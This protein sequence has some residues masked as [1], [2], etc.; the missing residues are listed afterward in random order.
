M[1][2]AGLTGRPIEVQ[3]V[4]V[5]SNEQLVIVRR[6]DGYRPIDE[7]QVNH[8]SCTGWVLRVVDHHITGSG[9]LCELR[10]RVI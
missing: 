6:V 8:L 10:P 2:N 4:G 9:R 1:G 5:L 7:R 3:V